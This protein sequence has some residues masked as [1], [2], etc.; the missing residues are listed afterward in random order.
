MNDAYKTITYGGFYSRLFYAQIIIDI[1]LQTS[2]DCGKKQ[3]VAKIR[4]LSYNERDGGN[5]DTYKCCS[6]L[7]YPELEVDKNVAE[8]KLLMPSYAGATSEQTAVMTYC[9]QSYISIAR[10]DF[11]KALIDIAK[12]EMKHHSLLGKTI[13][14]LGGYPVIGSRSYWSG[15]LVNYTLDPRKYLQQ[16]IIAEES[17][18]I[19]YERTILNLKSE[20]VKML[21][22]RIIL[23]E[24]VHIETFKE[25]LKTL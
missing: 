25:L 7:P 15:N 6:E 17:A 2:S 22:E 13:Y 12:C 4:R 19:N 11:A 9:F 24:E 5:M 3:T 16:N 21:L 23:D 20:S 1:R 14:L 18:I 10:P 8:S